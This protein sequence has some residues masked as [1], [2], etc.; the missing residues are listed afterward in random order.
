MTFEQHLTGMHP[1]L[2]AVIGSSFAW[3][4]TALGASAVFLAKNPSRRLL[5]GMLGFASGIML[6]A[7]YWSLLAPSIELAN[8]SCIP[9]VIGFLLGG[10]FIWVIDKILPHVHPGVQA[11]S[12]EGIRTSWQRSVLLVLAITIHNIPEGLVVGIA[13][14]AA[15][16]HGAA[17]TLGAAIALALGIAIQDF[18]EG[19]AVSIPLRSEGLSRRKAFFYGQLS[20]IVEPIGAIIGAASVMLAQAMLPYALAFGAGAMF[21]IIIEELVP[22]A[23]GGDESD[24]ST[25]AAM[26]G[27]VLMMIM[28]VVLG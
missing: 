3:F 28:D 10:A 16:A 8:G 20:G 24:V 4:M 21:Y 13:F 9:A 18:P 22:Q 7:T 19:L 26:F 12:T 1:V 5:S 27:F 14:G 2:Q 23:R 25:V 15:A 17:T 6:A 11:H